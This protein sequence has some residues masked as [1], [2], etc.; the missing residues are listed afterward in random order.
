MAFRLSRQ[1]SKK[2]G[3]SPQYIYIKTVS[4]LDLEH[5]IPSCLV[6]AEI[7]CYSVALPQQLLNRFKKAYC[8]HM[9]TVE[10]TMV[11]KIFINHAALVPDKKVPIYWH[12]FFS[13][14]SAKHVKRIKIF[15]K[16]QCFRE[17]L[18]EKSFPNGLLLEQ[19]GWKFVSSNLN[20]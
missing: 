17:I 11:E 4:S 8:P 14:F 9:Y 1:E 13:Y 12:A 15:T 7:E 10:F 3:N 16:Y 2:T 20:D 18:I 19:Q 5:L 6:S